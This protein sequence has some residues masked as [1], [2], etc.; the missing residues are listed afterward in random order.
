M[1]SPRISVQHRPAWR[2]RQSRLIAA[3]ASALVAGMLLAACAAGAPQT[4]NSP[5]ATNDS[6]QTGPVDEQPAQTVATIALAQTLTSIDP[7]TGIDANAGQAANQ[8]YEGLFRLDESGQ[9]IP[10]GAAALPEISEDGL[11]YTIELNRDAVWS[12]GTPVTAH[13]YVF[14]WRRNISHPTAAE[15][16]RT[17]EFVAGANAILFDGAP[18][19]DLGVVALDDWTLQVTLEAPTVFFTSLLATVPFFPQPAHFIEDIGE[20]MWATSADHVLFNGPFVLVDWAGPGLGSDWAYV[21]NETYW[22]ADQV[23]LERI[24]VRVIADTNTAINLFNAGEVDQVAI[25]GPQ[26]LALSDNEAFVANATSAVIFLGYNHN[27]PILSDQRAREAISLSINRALFV[28][29]VLNDGSIVAGGLVPPHLA[30]SPAGIDFAEEFGNQLPTDLDR[31]AELWAQVQDDHGFTE[32]TLDLQTFDSDRIVVTAEYLQEA[33]QNALD[34]LT[35]TVQPN[36]VSVFIDRAT[37]QQFDLYLPSWSAAF[38]DPSSHLSLF[39]TDAGSNWGLYSNP[40]FDALMHDAVVTYAADAQARWDVLL[41]AQALLM[42]DQGVTPIFTQPS[43]LLR[44]P[45]F[46][47]VEFL[48]SGPAFFFGNA[49]FT[50]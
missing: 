32:L 3:G 23:Q 8:F 16:Q 45:N 34:G 31:A 39:T 15:Q 14:A 26:V 35:V 47:G 17:V 40:E 5:A 19:E 13:D 49:Y 18:V 48:T 30:A 25:S 21:R 24:N 29:N 2:G 6:G 12:D 7:A 28:D 33:L 20:D 43:T 22:N 42:Q 9:P 1:K 44:N 46:R 11:V 37:S 4:T 38:P 36:P 41:A 27:H 10:F 50:Q